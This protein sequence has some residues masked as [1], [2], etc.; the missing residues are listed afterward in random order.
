MFFIRYNGGSVFI[1]PPLGPP[2]SRHP[3]MPAPTA[4]GRADPTPPAAIASEDVLKRLGKSRGSITGVVF[5]ADVAMKRLKTILSIAVAEPKALKLLVRG[6][7]DYLLGKMVVV[8]TANRTIFAIDDVEH[9]F[10][11]LWAIDMPSA[12][13]SGPLGDWHKPKPQPTPPTAPPRDSVRTASAAGKLA[14]LIERFRVHG[15]GQEWRLKD[16]WNLIDCLSDRGKDR[17]I[18][19]AGLWI[20]KRGEQT[21][22]VSAALKLTLK[23][24]AANRGKLVAWFHRYSPIVID[25]NHRSQNAQLA[26]KVDGKRPAFQHRAASANPF[27]LS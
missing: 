10:S 11:V 17:A 18:H 21:G 8:D 4:K 1:D 24:S 20:M 22:G 14:M 13:R 2:W 6:G 16:I 7:A 23:V 12:L 5:E 3:C 27:Y 25:L 19:A 9:S 26:K 15:L